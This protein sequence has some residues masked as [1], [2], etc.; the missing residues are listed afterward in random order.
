[1]T[2]RVT[3]EI[4]PFGDESKKKVLDVMN[5]SNITTPSWENDYGEVSDY[6]VRGHKR[7]AGF[8]ELIKKVLDR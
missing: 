2:L 6:I 8:W 4:I 3:V 1:M 5:I 7:K